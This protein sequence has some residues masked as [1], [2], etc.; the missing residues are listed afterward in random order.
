MKPLFVLSFALL[1]FNAVA[2]TQTPEA[3]ALLDWMPAS[4]GELSLDGAPVALTRQAEGKAYSMCSKTYKQDTVT[5]SIA[6]FD[7]KENPEMMTRSTKNWDKATKTDNDLL[8]AGTTTIGNFQA[9]ESFNK[10]DRKSELYVNLFGRY[11]LF[12]SVNNNTPEY[13]KEVVKQLRPEKL[14]H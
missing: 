2:Q 5:L 1:T 13:L 4:F 6:I 7:Y 10:K 8:R 11:L 12:L 9:W 3:Q 14:K